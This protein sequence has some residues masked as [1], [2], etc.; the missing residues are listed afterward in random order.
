MRLMQQ[1]LLR[2]VAVILAVVTIGCAGSKG[3]GQPE[4]ADA[5][6]GSDATD[7]IGADKR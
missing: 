6:L 4:Q 5:A 2:A 1:K 7:P 3:S